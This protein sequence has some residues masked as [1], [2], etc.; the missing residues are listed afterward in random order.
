MLRQAGFQ[1]PSPQQRRHD[2]SLGGG[3]RSASPDGGGTPLSY[4]HY[5]AA[6][7]LSPPAPQRRRPLA[8]LQRSRSGGHPLGAADGTVSF[9]QLFF[10]HALHVAASRVTVISA[11]LLLY[12]GRAVL[13]SWAHL[14]IWCVMSRCQPVSEA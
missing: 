13:A 6:S 5:G 11:A 9:D 8:A 7:L 2:A 1:T 14:D 3:G 12:A 4:S 10:C